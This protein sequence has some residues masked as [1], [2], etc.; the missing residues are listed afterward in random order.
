MRGWPAVQQGFDF[1]DGLP[2]HPSQLVQIPWFMAPSACHEPLSLAGMACHPPPPHDFFTISLFVAHYRV[3]PRGALTFAEGASG[4][5]ARPLHF[6]LAVTR[7]S[8][9]SRT[10]YR[11]HKGV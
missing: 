10:Y 7:S 9:A 1:H 8:S 3:F 6:M 11:H 2:E 5:P 4:Q